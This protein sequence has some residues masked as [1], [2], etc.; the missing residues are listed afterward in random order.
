MS[1]IDFSDKFKNK[2]Q[3]FDPDPRIESF[4]SHSGDF[5]EKFYNSIDEIK[6]DVSVPKDVCIQFETT[7]N[8]LLYSFF[9]YRMSTV[10]NL[11]AYSVLEK[12]I[13]EKYRQSN[14]NEF[15]NENPGLRKYM[16]LALKEGWIQRKDFYQCEL[17]NDDISDEASEEMLHMFVDIRNDLSHNPQSLNFLWEVVNHLKMFQVMINGM[18]I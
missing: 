4:T 17:S 13:K 14:L 7:K 8:V 6:L 3:I 5:F 18:F 15:K 11:Y 10:A 9:S 16:K 12:A 1:E 2:S